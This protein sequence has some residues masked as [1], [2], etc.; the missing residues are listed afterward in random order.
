MYARK[1]IL[2]ALV[3]TVVHDS[4]DWLSSRHIFLSSNSAFV[5][6]SC[7]IWSHFG[8]YLVA[9]YLL[10]RLA[11]K[12]YCTHFLLGHHH[13]ID[14]LCQS[15]MLGPSLHLN[16]SFLLPYDLPLFLPP[17]GASSLSSSSSKVLGAHFL[18]VGAYWFLNFYFSLVSNNFQRWWQTN[19]LFFPY[20]HLLVPLLCHVILIGLLR[21]FTFLRTSSVVCSPRCCVV[22][23]GPA[24]MRDWSPV[25]GSFFISSFFGLCASLMCRLVLKTM[26]VQSLG[27]NGIFFYI[28]IV[29]LSKNYA[30]RS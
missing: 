6:S 26:L 14:L 11:S 16:F 17:L 5:F 25:E 2:Y 7:L 9:S 30:M 1:C 12:C 8:I 21:G 29:P 18:G 3:D 22:G 10:T 24:T 27:V 15:F 19:G 28:N 20:G 13:P 4:F 23:L